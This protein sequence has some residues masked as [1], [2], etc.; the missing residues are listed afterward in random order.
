MVTSVV[1]LFLGDLSDCIVEMY[2][3]SGTR[4]N[5]NLEVT[6]GNVV[7]SEREFCVSANIRRSPGRI[8]QLTILRGTWRARRRRLN[9]SMLSTSRGTC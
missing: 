5:G 4:W 2:S 9:Q 6:N 1:G 7:N 8:A 3:V